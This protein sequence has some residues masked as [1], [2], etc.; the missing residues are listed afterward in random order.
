MGFSQEDKIIIKYLRLK[1]GYGSKRILDEHPEK[2][3]WTISGM[4]K[5]LRKIDETGDLQ[6]KEGSGRPKTVRTE[7]NIAEVRTLVLSQE[8]APGIFVFIH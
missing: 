4:D 8:N 1:C 7:E 5:L 2:E 3:E 6:R